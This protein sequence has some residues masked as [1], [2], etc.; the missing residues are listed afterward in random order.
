[1]HALFGAASACLLKVFHSPAAKRNLAEATVRKRQREN[2]CTGGAAMVD[3]L[4]ATWDMT[5]FNSLPH[6]KRPGLIRDVQRGH[7]EVKPLRPA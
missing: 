6:E 3:E 4:V 1:M 7:I 5:S 2:F